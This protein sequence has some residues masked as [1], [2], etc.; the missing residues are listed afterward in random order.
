MKGIILAGGSGTRLYPL[1]LAVSKQILPI[2]DKP[3]IYYP[4]SVLMLAG[5]RE[6]LVI[7][8]PR[9]LPV[10][11]D[12]LGDGSEFGLNM[13]YAEQPHPNGLAEAFIIGRDFIG[14]DS[15]SMILGDNIYFGEGL[16]QLCRK[17]ASCE[18]G[19]SV[20]AYHV[21][22]PQRYGVVSFDKVS[23]SALTIEEKPQAPKSNWAITGL[24]FYDNDV[25]NIAPTIRPSERGELEITAVNNVYL[26]RGQLQVHQL[27]RGY[28]WLD[29]GTHDSLHEASSFVRTIEHRQGIKVACPEEIAFEQGW[30]T[31][32]KVLQRADR[33]GKNEYAAYLRRRVVELTES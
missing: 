21:E 5:I 29:T 7:S 17:A 12:L 32:D 10:F 33:L 31:A 24:Y 14:N 22:D 18:S 2:Y 9:D 30:L 23:G 27:G 19:A 25:V 26:E 20:F 28:A 13:S 15:V 8:T 4:L 16:S 11:R 6:I 1:T 3:M